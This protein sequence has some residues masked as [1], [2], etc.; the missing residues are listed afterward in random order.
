[1]FKGTSRIKCSSSW[2]ECNVHSDL[3][4]NNV[5]C[6]VAP[7]P[8]NQPIRQKSVKSRRSLEMG[9]RLLLIL[10]SY[11]VRNRLNSAHMVSRTPCN[12]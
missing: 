1:M 7:Q 8:T 12:N 4:L 11:D 6:F 9:A 10:I 3:N 2:A 5:I